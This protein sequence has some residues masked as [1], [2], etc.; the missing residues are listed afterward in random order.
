MSR[1]LTDSYPHYFLLWSNQTKSGQG[2]FWK[3]RYN[4]SARKA[5]RMEL[6]GLRPKLRTLAYYAS[7]CNYKNH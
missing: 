7:Q 3:R 5:A 4:K 1:R 2:K 6:L